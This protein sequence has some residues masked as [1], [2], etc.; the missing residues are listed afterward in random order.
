MTLD[1]RDLLSATATGVLSLA[2]CTGGGGD[3]SGADGGGGSPT[4]TTAMDADAQSSA[5]VTVTLRNVAF[6]PRKATVAPG[7]RVAWVNEDDVPH[8]VTSVQ[9]H[10][11][12]ASW[13]LDERIPGGERFTHTFDGSG[14]YEYYCTVHG[15]TTM[16]G[17][18]LVG[19]ATLDA[20]LPCASEGGGGGGGYY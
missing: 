7:D 17:A 20:S 1:R 10:D 9:F 19:D 6:Q 8:T 3:G 5:A 14:V 11:A 18:V 12:A 15:R 16:C 2:G 4:D 13:S